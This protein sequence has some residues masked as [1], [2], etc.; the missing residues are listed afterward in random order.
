MD[1]DLGPD[2]PMAGGMVM[3]AGHTLGY[4]HRPG[5][6]GEMSPFIA[7][8]PALSAIHADAVV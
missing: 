5:R 2:R 7:R 6:T 3:R 4:R 1:F 8:A